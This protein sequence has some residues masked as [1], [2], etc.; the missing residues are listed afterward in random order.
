MTLSKAPCSIPLARVPVTWTPSAIRGSPGLSNFIRPD[1]EFARM[2]GSPLTTTVGKPVRTVWTITGITKGSREDAVAS[3]E[4]SMYSMELGLRVSR[5]VTEVRSVTEDVRLCRSVINGSV[6]F[7][8]PRTY[9][10][11]LVAALTGPKGCKLSAVT[12]ASAMIALKRIL[13]NCF[14]FCVAYFFCFHVSFAEGI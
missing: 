1:T 5:L 12:S 3:Q 2:D 9:T 8:T 6:G 10:F 13:E 7:E 11:A 4:P 14:N